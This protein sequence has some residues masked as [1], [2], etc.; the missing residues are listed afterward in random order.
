MTSL[1]NNSNDSIKL[2]ELDESLINTSNKDCPL[3]KRIKTFEDNLN[4]KFLPT[5]NLLIK[6]SIS[7]IKNNDDIKSLIEHLYQKWNPDFIIVHSN[8][9]MLYYNKKYSLDKYD[10]YLNNKEKLCDIEYK[11]Y[12]DNNNTIVF[13][14]THEFNGRNQKLLSVIS[15][16]CGVFLFNYLKYD[17]N[18]I[19]IN[20]TLNTILQDELN[21]L[22]TNVNT[23]CYKRIKYFCK[24]TDKDFEENL[25]YIKY[26]KQYIHKKKLFLLQFENDFN[27][28]DFLTEKLFII[29]D[30]IILENNINLSYEDL[31]NEITNNNNINKLNN[32]KIIEDNII[33]NKSSDVYKLDNKF[34]NKISNTDFYVI[35]LDG[36]NFSK[37]TK[38]F[39][40]PYDVKFIK[41]LNYTVKDIMEHFNP[42]SIFNQ[43]DEITLNFIPS[44]NVLFTGDV[45]S[46]ISKI[47]TFTSIRFN[48]HLNNLLSKDNNEYKNIN[49]ILSYYPIFDAR[50]MIFNSID[51][52]EMLNHLIWRSTID[53]ER[54][55]ILMFG[56]NKYKHKILQGKNTLEVKNMLANDFKI[57]WNEDVELFI[58]NGIFCKKFNNEIKFFQHKIIDKENN[59]NNHEYNFELLLTNNF[60]NINDNQFLDIDEL[61]LKNKNLTLNSNVIN[62][63]NIN[64]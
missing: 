1:S 52:I 30:N 22:L 3:A 20:I 39:V 43:S 29:N 51:S 26:N 55:A 17:P 60:T 24:L 50:I 42:I 44:D 27:N 64:T 10:E 49:T 6:M 4:H 54:N 28:I 19:D 14:S 32:F 45:N 48:Y 59:N 58:R 15:S 38:N 40:K 61:T 62:I 35:R 53:C 41:V 56:Q 36:K 5:D 63:A 23:F 57:Y 47:A 7:N 9:I 46:I 31:L 34:N 18:D 12:R 11:K 25:N 21:L 37:F 2:N 8:D 13:N 16:S 33:F